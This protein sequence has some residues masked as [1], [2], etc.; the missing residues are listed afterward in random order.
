MHTTAKAVLNH[1][2][3]E[4]KAEV[5]RTERARQISLAD[6]QEAEGAMISRY[7]TFLEEA[8]YL[9][10]GQNK[11]LLEAKAVIASLEALLLNN[12]DVSQIASAGSL[13]R[14]ENI[15][16][17][18]NRVYFL[19]IEGAGGFVFTT[20]DDEKITVLSVTSPLGKDLLRKEVGS[21]IESTLLKDVWEI[22]KIE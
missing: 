5:D 22:R 1:L 18:E 11:R 10:G 2:L 7:D 20:P 21:E 13:V 8:Q 15:T 6:A 12:P 19:I 3:V 16:T 9:A 17:G 4:K 14:L